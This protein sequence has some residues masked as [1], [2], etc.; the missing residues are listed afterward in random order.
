MKFS[1]AYGSRKGGRPYNQDRL[2][3]SKTDEALLMAVADGMGGYAGG[4]LAAQ[5]AIDHLAGA[6]RADARPRLADPE[7]FLQREIAAAHLTI[8]HRGINEGLGESPRT[9]LVACIVQSGYAY[10]SFIGDSRLYLIREGRV[11]AR[12]RDH[13]MIQQLVDAGRIREEAVAVHPERNKLL[14]CLGGQTL[15]RPE[16]AAS[17]R[18][19]KGDLL[20]LCSDGLWGPLS[21]RRLL[22]SLIGKEPARALPEV[23]ALAEAYGGADCDNVSAVAMQWQEEAVLD[24]AVC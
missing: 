7:A 11:A 23:M 20:L 9:T 3:T 18:L 24:L 8:V 2:G 4:E 22:T 21:P 15:P 13:S 19:A 16:P 10:W 1:I 14:R 17:A 12:T 6:F 5:A